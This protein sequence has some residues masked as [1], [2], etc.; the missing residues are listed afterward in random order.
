MRNTR[1][2]VLRG[3]LIL[4]IVCVTHGIF[5]LQFPFQLLASCFLFEMPAIFMIS[6][7]S[8]YLWECNLTQPNACQT[9]LCQYFTFLV[10]RVSKILIPYF[11]YAGACILTVVTQ[12]TQHEDIDMVGLLQA[13]LNP[14]VY[15]RGFTVSALNW[16]LWFIPVFLLITAIFPLTRRI[17]LGTNSSVW[18]IALAFLG[19]QIV[20]QDFSFPAESLVKETLFYLMFT[21]AGYRLAKLGR[22]IQEIHLVAAASGSA[23]QMILVFAYT[24]NLDVLNMQ[25]NK[26]PPNYLF[27]IFSV[28]WMSIFLLM[29]KRWHNLTRKVE[30]LGTS[31]YLR[32]FLS[33]GYSI[34]LWQGLAYTVSIRFGSQ[35]EAPPLTVLASSV[36]LS[37]VLG[38]AFSFA[39]RI[40]LL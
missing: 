17:A 36:I 32:P 15:G 38:V 16:H 30:K 12:G 22:D 34:Y 3:M 35:I 23:V 40:R 28:F 19:L 13:W 25:R 27:F 10:S 37:L 20:L 31:S 18:C 14:F 2:D 4:Y 1:V 9:P 5:W 21:L 33:A 24:Q 39:E 8:Y 26:F 7:Y 11:V 6:G 29:G